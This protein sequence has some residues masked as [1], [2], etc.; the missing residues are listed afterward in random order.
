MHKHMVSNLK[1]E[2]DKFKAWADAYPEE[3]RSGEWECDYSDWNS[4]SEAF[5]ELIST[6]APSDLS[7]GDIDNIIFSIARDNE[8]EDLISYLAENIDMFTYLLPYVVKSSESDAKWQFAVTLGSEAA[9]SDVAEE[10]LLQ[11]VSDPD[12]YT[13]RRA[14]QS[15]GKVKS[16]HTEKYCIKAWASDHEYQRIMALWVLKDIGSSY[17]PKYIEL[18]ISDGRK[19]LVQNAIELK[20]A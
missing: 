13:S 2:I 7:E 11:L 14:L 15:L 8:I 10:T 1:H 4:L 19:Y 20:N 17:L 5:N 16:H 3:T 12:E 18:G 6:K 9:F